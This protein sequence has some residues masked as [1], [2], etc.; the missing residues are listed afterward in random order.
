[1]AVDHTRMTV[2]ALISSAQADQYEIS[3]SIVRFRIKRTV[4][5]C[6]QIVMDI[7]TN[8]ITID[9]PELQ[10]FFTALKGTVE[11]IERLYKTG[12]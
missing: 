11:R 9:S 12:V 6:R 4:E 3:A 2:W 1:M 5:M 10:E 8:E 7:D